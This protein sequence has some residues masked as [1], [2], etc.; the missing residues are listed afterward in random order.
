MT[1]NSNDN[2]SDLA[3][4]EFLKIC[5]RMCTKRTDHVPIR[6]WDYYIDGNEEEQWGYGYREVMIAQFEQD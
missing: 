6:Y 1:Y 2:D 3:L 5:F 4:F